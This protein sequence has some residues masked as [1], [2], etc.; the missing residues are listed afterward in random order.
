MD[1]FEPTEY[2]DLSKEY[3][4]LTRDDVYKAVLDLQSVTER[5]VTG[6][7]IRRPPHPYL[8]PEPSALWDDYV[9]RGGATTITIPGLG[10]YSYNEWGKYEKI[11]PYAIVH[12][13]VSRD[14]MPNTILDTL[15]ILKGNLMRELCTNKVKKVECHMTPAVKANLIQAYKRLEMYG[16]EMPFI[17]CCTDMAE[18]LPARLDLEDMKG[19]EVHIVDPAD[20]GEFYLDLKGY[21]RK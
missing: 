12:C 15:S 9:H 19:I 1:T 3:T 4:A 21:S 17:P 14:L 6:E 13:N 20:N 7:L 16:K 5:S 18:L 2:T 10:D 8:A 11:K